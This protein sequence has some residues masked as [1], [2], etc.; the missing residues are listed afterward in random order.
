MLP[1][2]TLYNGLIISKLLLFLREVRFSEEEFFASIPISYIKYDY[3][4]SQ[5]HNLFYP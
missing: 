1:R 2:C 4:E 3:P 5:N